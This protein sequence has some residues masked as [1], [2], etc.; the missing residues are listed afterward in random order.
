MNQEL[1]K[2]SLR[3]LYS[4]P[5]PGMQ[6]PYCLDLTEGWILL[7]V[8][9][10]SVRNYYCPLSVR[11]EK[12]M[13]LLMLI[14]VDVTVVSQQQRRQ[15]IINLEITVA[16]KFSTILFFDSWVMKV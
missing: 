5:A 7:R 1:E 8:S 12:R 3:E 2:K 11:E 16:S 14:L 6:L 15:F 10:L 9:V 4:T 13:H